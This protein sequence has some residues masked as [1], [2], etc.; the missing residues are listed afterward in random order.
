MSAKDL[1]EFDKDMKMVITDNTLAIEGKGKV[2]Y[3]L[4]S[5]HRIML[6]NNKTD[7]P[8]Q[9]NKGD[10]RK[11]IIR[12][13]DS[14][15]GDG[16][17]FKTLYSCVED[18]DVMTLLFNSFMTRD[19]STFNSERGREIPKTEFQLD[20]IESYSNP[21]ELWLKDLIHFRYLDKTTEEYSEELTWTASEQL[22]SYRSWCENNGVKLELSSLA[23]GVRIKNL[24]VEGISNKHTNRGGL[25]IFNL[26]KMEVFFK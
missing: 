20:I 16:E 24:K 12:S 23:L 21:V 3:K 13:C 2:I 15:I 9:T 1:H 22:S 10:R 14:K 25:R 7:N 5:L 19:V 4:H 17:Y 6:F 8:I 18:L 11:L 26:E